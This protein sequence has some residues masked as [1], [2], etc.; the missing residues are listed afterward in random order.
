MN[1]LLLIVSSCQRICPY[2]YSVLILSGQVNDTSHTCQA[3]ENLESPILHSLWVQDRGSFHIR[4]A[5]PHWP[6]IWVRRLIT[7]VVS[8]YDHWPTFCTICPMQWNFCEMQ[9]N[10]KKFLL[11]RRMRQGCILASLLFSSLIDKLN[12]QSLH[13]PKLENRHISIL[14]YADDAV[15][16]SQT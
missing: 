5:P 12:S 16:L 11:K 2:S 1:L 14:L 4:W 3:N 13:P 7:D 6:P 9:W 10:P 8:Y 15:Q